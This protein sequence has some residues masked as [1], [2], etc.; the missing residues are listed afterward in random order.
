VATVEPDEFCFALT[1]TN[2]KNKNMK[3]S[4]PKEWLLSR[5]HLEEGLEIGAG[6]SPHL[7]TPAPAYI[8]GS[9]KLTTIKQRLAFGLFVTLMRR[10]FGWS[11]QQLAE[12]AE[13][14]PSEITLIEKDPHYEAELCTGNRPCQVVQGTH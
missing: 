12:K 1:Q 3:I 2:T 13:T 11:I 5:A 10:K 7:S 6:A 8:V 14:E 9:E 4:I